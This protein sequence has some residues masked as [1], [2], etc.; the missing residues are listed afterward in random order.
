[1]FSYIDKRIDMD[2]SVIEQRR[3]ELLDKLYTEVHP[4]AIFAD[5]DEAQRVVFVMSDEIA[6]TIRL[7]LKDARR[8]TYE[9][10]ALAVVNLAAQTEDGFNQVF[11][12]AHFQF[13]NI[14]TADGVVSVAR[15]RLG[16]GEIE[17]HSHVYHRPDYLDEVDVADLIA[18]IEGPAWVHPQTKQMNPAQRVFGIL[19]IHRNGL[20]RLQF[21]IHDLRENLVAWNNY[22]LK[23]FGKVMSLPNAF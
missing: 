6:D 15:E 9:S 10:S 21:Y 12:L 3:L 5:L 4:L 17:I 1:M 8:R 13:E 22:G 23:K 11:G 19:S 20:A 7:G 16:A 14:G 18:A 2:A